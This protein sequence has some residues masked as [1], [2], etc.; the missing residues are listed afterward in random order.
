MF[1]LILS[2]PLVQAAAVTVLSEVA[3]RGVLWYFD[4]K[5]DEAAYRVA[6]KIVA[7]EK[8]NKGK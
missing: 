5:I 2:N 7:E 1:K 3:Q 6:E 4:E 8:K